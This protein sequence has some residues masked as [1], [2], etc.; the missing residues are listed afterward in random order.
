VP[1]VERFLVYRSART[2]GNQLL[3][4]MSDQSGDAPRITR[5]LE[6]QGERGLGIVD[7]QFRQSSGIK[8]FAALCKLR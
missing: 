3:R 6:E 1:A 8:S 2:S 4:G 5:L 7:S